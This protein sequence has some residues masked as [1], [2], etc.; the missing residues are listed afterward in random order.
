MRRIDRAIRL[1]DTQLLG[2]LLRAEPA[3]VGLGEALG[4][5]RVQ[6]KTQAAFLLGVTRGAV[7]GAALAVVA[8]NALA[9][10][11][12]GHF[13][14]NTVQQ[15]KRSTPLLGRQVGEQT[16][17]TQQVA[18]QPAAV[19]PGRAETGGLRLDD[20]NVQLRRLALEVIGRPQAGVTSADDGHVDVQLVLQ[21]RPRHKRVVQLVHP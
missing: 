5:E 18:H 4:I 3:V 20:R 8:I 12:L 13:V 7:Q 19:T 9:G 6:V 15:V 14:G 16:V 11:H 1:G 21:A 2:Q 10:Q 17:F